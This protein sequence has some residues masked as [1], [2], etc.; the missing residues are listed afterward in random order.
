MDWFVGIQAFM[1]V[2]ALIALWR[3]DGRSGQF[4][5]ML[6]V[7]SEGVEIARVPFVTITV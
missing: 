4:R 3:R 6:L 5:T 2:L 7:E 1:K